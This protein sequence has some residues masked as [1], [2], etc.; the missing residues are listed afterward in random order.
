MDSDPY[1]NLT[2]KDDYLLRTSQK[3]Y[4]KTIIELLAIGAVASGS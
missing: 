4:V 3:Y 2:T 1:K